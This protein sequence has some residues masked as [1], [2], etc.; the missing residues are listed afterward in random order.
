MNYNH[1]ICFIEHFAVHFPTYRNKQINYSYRV[2]D[3]CLNLCRNGE[4]FRITKKPTH[5]MQ[6][7]HQFL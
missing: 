6:S 4:N 3:E 1:T 7:E 2:F 5:N